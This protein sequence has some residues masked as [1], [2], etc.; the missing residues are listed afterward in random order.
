MTSWNKLLIASS[1]AIF[2]KASPVM[3]DT[4]PL[5]ET[6]AVFSSSDDA[7]DWSDYQ[8]PAHPLTI[9]SS[10]PTPIEGYRWPK[11]KIYIY[12]ASSDPKIRTAFQ[13]AVKQWNHLKIVH[14]IWTH[15][16]SKAG[17]IARAGDLSAS[18]ANNSNYQNQQSELGETET[19]YNDQYHVIV[20]AYSTLDPNQ[21]DYSSRLFRSQ[22]AAH[23]IG[24]ALG[25]AHAPEYEHSIMIPRNPCSGITKNDKRTL[26][27]LYH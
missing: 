13:D 25:L 16:R 21:L 18:S 4:P 20:K 3:A 15:K 12:L 23:E 24:H 17:I 14:I 1:L 10:T 7:D 9:P 19:R 6:P 26:A 11:K 2:A 27:L 5:Q 22:V 8:L